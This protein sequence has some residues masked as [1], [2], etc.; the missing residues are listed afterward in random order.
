MYVIH[1]LKLVVAILVHHPLLCNADR[2]GLA[3]E[4]RDVT[5]KCDVT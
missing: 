1:Q 2:V 4:I 3:N 5:V